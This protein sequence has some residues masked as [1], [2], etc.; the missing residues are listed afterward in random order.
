[1]HAFAM[2]LQLLPSTQFSFC[3]SVI[4]IVP[5]GPGG[6]CIIYGAVMFFSNGFLGLGNDEERCEM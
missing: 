1:M 4:H 5:I 2:D 6:M 3:E